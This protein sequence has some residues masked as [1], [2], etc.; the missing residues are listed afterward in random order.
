[1]SEALIALLGAMVGA[2]LVW[3][4]SLRRRVES[5][6]GEREAIERRRAELLEE[7][8]EAVEEAEAQAEAE[9]ERIEGER[10]E[11]L[12]DWIARRFGRGARPDGG[13]G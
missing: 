1:M 7:E 13:D 3:A 8:E 2:L 5:L 6:P 12:L 11:S 4:L 9:R 10:D